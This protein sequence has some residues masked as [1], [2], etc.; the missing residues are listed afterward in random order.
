MQD[1]RGTRE[2]QRA[3][4]RVQRQAEKKRVIQRAAISTRQSSIRATFATRGSSAGLDQSKPKMGVQEQRKRAHK[5]V[6]RGDRQ[7]ILSQEKAFGL[8]G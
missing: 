1:Q 2:D 3:K 7:S 4:N 5:Q 8:Y 6:I